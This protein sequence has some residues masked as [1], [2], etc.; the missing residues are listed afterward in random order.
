MPTILRVV[1]FAVGVWMV[2]AVITSAVRTVVVPRALPS[3]LSRV[4]FGGLRRAFDLVGRRR[5]SYHDRDSV[6]ARYAPYA[7]LLLPVTWALGIFA[8]YV[9]MFS[10]VENNGLREAFAQSGSS[11]FTLGFERP[12]GVFGEALAFSEALLGLGVI[13][14]MLSYLPAIYAAYQR[15]EALVTLLATYAGAPASPVDLIVR[16]ARVG[17]LHRLVRIN[18]QWEPWFADVEESHSTLAALA[19]FRSPDPD[20][21]WITAAG[22]VLDSA[23]LTAACLDIPREPD[24]ELCLR[25]G[26]LCLRRIAN[27]FAIEN[28]QDPAPDAPIS[29]R[30]EE[31]DS[32]LSSLAEAGVPLKRDHDQMW[33]DFAG[34]R[35]NYDASLLGLTRLVLAP[36]ALWSSDRAGEYR[37]P[38][39]DPDPR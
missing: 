14:L 25:A 38:P 11:L 9:L 7:L 33:R 37:V 12:D 1:V 31:F 4:V 2:L 27:F 3:R 32:A 18:H 23:A 5:R 21:S 34:W 35:V 39:P 16:H 22:C 15:R 10:A 24:A 20:R 36:P 13:T 8:G 6:M 19:F 28:P 26:F 29:V 17:G 30:R